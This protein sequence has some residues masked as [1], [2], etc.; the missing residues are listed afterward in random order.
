MTDIFLFA[1]EHSGDIYGG[2]L[3][4]SLKE[5]VPNATAYGVGGPLMRDQGLECVMHMEEFQLMGFADIIRKFP[6]IWKQFYYLRDTILARKP[7][8]VV[9]IDYPGF[10]L[11][12]AKALRKKGFQGKIVHYVCPTVWAWGKGRIKTLVD[13]LDLLLTIFP[14]EPPIFEQTP[15]KTQF[16][17]HPLV[18]TLHSHPYQ[19]DWREKVGLKQGPNLLALF[20]GSR[21]G[22]VARLLK[23][24][25]EAANKLREE[26]PDLQIAVSCA[27]IKVESLIHKIAQECGLTVGKDVFLVPRH[28]SYELMK[29][30]RSA[31]AK[32][33][34]VNLELAM[35][36]KPCVVVYEVST[37]NYLI[38]WYLVRL[39]L[40][41]YSIVNILCN[42]RIYPE[43]VTETFSSQTLYESIASL[44]REGPERQACLAGCRQARNSLLTHETTSASDRAAQAIYQLCEV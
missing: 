11:R 33:G 20:P 16:V 1:G 17:G 10:N 13:T 24:Q 30:C 42:Q 3:L 31:I 35:H 36:Q 9:L 21:M 19:A 25:F 41:H 4:T 7:D 22:E 14:F 27:D 5:L 26:H 15:L 23:R 40:D 18:E 28:Y 39:N 12:L 37:I 34:T 6:K 44:H 8:V 43:L 38:L 32:S 2:K 29:D